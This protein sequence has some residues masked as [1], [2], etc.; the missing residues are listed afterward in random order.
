MKP[1]I[2]EWDATAK[3][4]QA[5]AGETNAP[6]TFGLTNVS[7][8][9]VIIYDTSTSCDCTVAD[10]PTKPWSLPANASGQIHASINLHGKSGVVTNSIIVFTSKGNRRLNVKA[11]AP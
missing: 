3:E 5:N 9:T 7:S 4:Y 11:I 8:G 6:F 10:L 2:L 1:G